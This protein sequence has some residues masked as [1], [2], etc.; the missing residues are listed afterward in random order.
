M[1]VIE[2]AQLTVTERTVVSI[3]LQDA[4]RC[5]CAAEQAIGSTTRFRRLVKL[6]FGSGRP[7]PLA[8]PRLEAIRRFVCANRRRD[9]T[10]DLATPLADHGLSESQ[11]AALA[12]LSR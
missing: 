4:E 2:E 6:L 3:A 12:H 11:I 9:T 8:D 5:G 10:E 7:T 1:T